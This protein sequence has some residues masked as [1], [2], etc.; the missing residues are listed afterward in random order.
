MTRFRSI[1]ET[2]KISG[3]IVIN[4]TSLVSM[5]K[6]FC[7]TSHWRRRFVWCA[8]YIFVFES[9]NANERGNV[10][11][12]NRIIYALSESLLLHNILGA[13]RSHPLFLRNHRQKVK[14]RWA[15]HGSKILIPSSSTLNGRKILY[16]VRPFCM[17]FHSRK[18]NY[19]CCHCQHNKL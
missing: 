10:H 19:V 8:L 3:N 15:N 2:K 7:R 6:S 12:I 11:M 18:F 16:S 5:R 14:V 4:W 9:R 13:M 1:R 17:Q